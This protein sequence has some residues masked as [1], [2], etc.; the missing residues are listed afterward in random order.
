MIPEKTSHKKILIRNTIVLSGMTFLPLAIATYL[1]YSTTL[2]VHLE[3]VLGLE[4]A[5]LSKHNNIVQEPFQHVINDLCIIPE[6]HEFR[7]YLAG[8]LGN[9]DVT[10][11][12]LKISYIVDQYDQ[13]R[14]IDQNGNEN[15]RINNPGGQ[16]FSVDTGLLQNKSKRYYFEE[17]VRLNDG[18]IFISPI[19]LNIENGKIEEPYKPMIRFATPVYEKEDLAGVMI[20]NYRAERLIAN[21]IRSLESPEA[22]YMLV[23]SDGFW[24]HNNN[25]E[26]EW[27][28]MFSNNN[29]VKNQ[30]PEFWQDIQT[31][32]FGTHTGPEGAFVFHKITYPENLLDCN[33]QTLNS[34]AGSGSYWWSISHFSPNA[35]GNMR[36]PYS[37][38][39]NAFFAIAF[40]FSAS[41]GFTAALYLDQRRSREDTILDMALHDKLTG[42]ENRRS[43]SEKL[44]LEIE[45]CKRS[46]NSLAVL[47]MDLDGFKEINDTFGHDLGDQVLIDIGTILTKNIRQIDTCARFGGDEFVV[48]LSTVS[49]PD[50]AL[51]K[52]N[53]ILARVNQQ[54]WRGKSVG[55]SIGIAIFPEDAETTH[56]LIKHAD[57]AMYLAKESGKNTVRF[58]RDA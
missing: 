33:K 40:I 28:F 49:Q 50:D 24:I 15:L 58:A 5:T 21:I 27:G 52:A 56:D 41:L 57:G 36:A 48:L 53:D 12:I 19:D 51:A 11:D 34:L 35:I 2:N 18:N 47:Y 16:P 25:A 26:L 46:G 14:L 39:R 32:D 20:I 1:V 6:L 29:S 30:Y 37:L 55:I 44:N 38:Y 22:E 23:N 9:S 17:T 7:N 42:L 4:L 13:I 31:K 3:N 45:R 54:S 10:D 43:F 8:I